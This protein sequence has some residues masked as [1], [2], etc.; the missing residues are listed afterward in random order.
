MGAV[1]KFLVNCADIKVDVGELE[2]L[3]EPEDD[4]VCLRYVMKYSTRR[5]SNIFLFFD[6]SREKGPPCCNQKDV[7]W[8][9]KETRVVMQERWPNEWH[10]H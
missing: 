2:R 8:S 6:T 4:A 5:G 10:G 7:G 9:T 3:I 1:E